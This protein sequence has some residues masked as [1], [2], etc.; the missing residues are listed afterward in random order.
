EEYTRAG[1]DRESLAPDPFRQFELWF[2]QA[3]EA[4]LPE[5][6]AMSLATAS[7][8]GAPSLRTVLLKYFDNKGF[9]FFTNYSSHKAR[10]ITENPAVALMF[11]WITLERQVIVRGRAEKVS[12]AESLRYFS[13]RPQGSQ[14]GAWVSHQSS[15]ISDRKLLEMKLDEIKRKFKAGKIPLPDFWGGY[16]VVPE[17]VEFWQGRPSRLHDR[18]LYTLDGAAQWQIDRLSP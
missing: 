6:N 14:L 16:R 9:V 11:P 1:L 3:R 18:F 2:K 15:V 10:D 7:T 17:K 13:S 4:E 5:P 8:S 12:S